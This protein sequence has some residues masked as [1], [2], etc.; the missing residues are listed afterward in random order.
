MLKNNQTLSRCKVQKEEFQN[1]A[2][3]QNTLP[4]HVC[5]TYFQIAIDYQKR[6]TSLSPQVRL[7]QSLSLWN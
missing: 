1:A 3:K 6:Q 5:Q 7:Q 2:N 4:T